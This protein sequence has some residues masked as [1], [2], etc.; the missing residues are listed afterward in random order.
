MHLALEKLECS[1]MDVT[2]AMDCH[3]FSNTEVVGNEGDITDEYFV[4]V[5]FL[6]VFEIVVEFVLPLTLDQSLEL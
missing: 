5:A 4:L 3:T 6:L 1:G 2:A